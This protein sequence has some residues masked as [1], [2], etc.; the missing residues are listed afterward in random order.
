VAAA[1]RDIAGTNVENDGLVFDVDGLEVHA[2]REDNAYGGIRA[3]MQARLAEARVH[4]QIDV[5]FGDAITPAA[6]DLEFPTLLTDMPAPNVLAAFTP[7]GRAIAS[8]P[9]NRSVK[10]SV[11]TSAGSRRPRP[12]GSPCGTITAACISAPTFNTRSR[13]SA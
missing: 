11:P 5:G 4:V 9:S 1:V 7:H 13:F 10:G 12:R 3:V 2:I 8:K 6:S